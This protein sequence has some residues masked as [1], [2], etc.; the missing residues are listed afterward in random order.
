MDVQFYVI[1]SPTQWQSYGALD[2]KR[3]QLS[4]KYI[5]QTIP[6]E[7]INHYRINTVSNE[8]R[9]RSDLFPVLGYLKRLRDA[10]DYSILSLLKQSA[11]SFDVTVDGS[12]SDIDAY[13]EAVKG[14]GPISAPGS[15]FVHSKYITRELVAPT[16][17]KGSSGGAFEWTL[18]LICAGLGIPVSY[19]GT[20]LSG[21]QTRASALVSTEPFAKKCEM[22]QDVYTQCVQDLWDY[23]ME[24]FG[25]NAEC[26]ITFPEIAVADRSEKIRDIDY[27][28]RG[29][30][31]SRRQASP[32]VA[33]E[34]EI[35]PYDFDQTQ[36]EIKDEKED[37]GPLT[38][39]PGVET[40][41]GE[42]LDST[43]PSSSEKQDQA[44]EGLI[45]TS[46]QD[47]E[48]TDDL[49]DSA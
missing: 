23:C 43:L 49:E 1:I 19:L 10:V 34:L 3:K 18:S 45:R 42:A 37:F 29:N 9:G 40:P 30:Y 31:I 22:R 28:L 13:T 2:P 48:D 33:K 11:W 12:Q 20:H 26:T 8:K 16:A 44:S 7:Q 15:E 6:S 32:L 35:E 47:E 41:E 38:A 4:A 21:G 14:L 36:E 39:P 46:S 25:L 17:G 24:S 5:F 27:A